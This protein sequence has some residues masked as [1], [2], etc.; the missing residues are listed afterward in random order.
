MMNTITKKQ[1]YAYE[2]KR[3]GRGWRIFNVFN[4]IAIIL[5]SLLFLIPYWMIVAAS[6][7]DEYTLITKGYGILFRGFSF[8]AYK[9]IFTQNDKILLSLKNS[10]IITLGNS[11]FCLL[12]SGLFAYPLTCKDFKGKKLL[13]IFLIIP[14]FFGGGMVPTF[15]VTSTFF[16]DSIWALIIPGAC[17][18]Y[19]VILI[20]NFMYGIPDSL[21]EA[22]KIDGANDMLIFITIILPLSVPVFC[23]IFLYAAVSAWNNWMGPLLYL[24]DE[25][26]YP[27][28][29]FIQQVLNNINSMYS[30]TSTS[31]VPSESVKMACVIVGSLPMIIIYPFIQKYFIQGTNV[32]AVKE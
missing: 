25:T 13:S 22:A 5:V 6:L 24:T 16:Y 9:F 29:Y 1:T 21:K 18:P 7:S 14:M 4:V 12:V 23:T 11:F 20:R 10:V 31:I 17:A 32:G 26:K 30:S 19:Y 15:L 28:Q 3:R 27:L 2:R 8:E